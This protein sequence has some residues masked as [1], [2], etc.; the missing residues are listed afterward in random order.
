M[1]RAIFGNFIRRLCATRIAVVDFK[2]Y[3]KRSLCRVFFSWSIG[4]F[5]IG[6]SFFLCVD[7]DHDDRF[8]TIKG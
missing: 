5:V 8:M 2:S 6:E 1:H 7:D 3:K 4:L